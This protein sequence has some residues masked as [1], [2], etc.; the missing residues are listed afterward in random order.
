MR[1]K[2]KN[3]ARLASL[4]ALGAGALGV[5][6]GTAHAG[7]I[8][9]P[10]AG[11]VG[12][13]SGY[14]QG[15]GVGVTSSASFSLGRTNTGFSRTSNRFIY[16]QGYNLKFKLGDAAFGQKWTALG[17]APAS[18]VKLGLRQSILKTGSRP[19]SGYFTTTTGGALV[20]QSTSQ[21]YS[22]WVRGHSGTNGNFYK[23]FQ[24]TGS[25]PLSG[26]YGWVYFQQSVS[27]TTGPDVHILGMAYDD[28]G[29]Q[30]P[31]GDT[32]VPEP[33]TMAMTGLAALALGA[34]G[35]R[36]W[37]AARKPAA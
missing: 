16:I 13:S 7:V 24:F 14:H 3:V 5:A 20:H 11:K 4:S 36:R 25:S 29:N 23:L 31:A 15:W 8:Y 26:D 22:Y 32:S 27:D 21:P 12:F 35:L 33:A 9:T 30:L 37:R 1:I 28:Q 6:A 18:Y 34:T 2:K 17:G 10:L 19:G